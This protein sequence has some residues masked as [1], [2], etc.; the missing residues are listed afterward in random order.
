MELIVNYAETGLVLSLSLW[1]V[2]VCRPS[3]SHSQKIDCSVGKDSE[4][5]FWHGMLG[6]YLLKIGFFGQFWHGLFCYI[7]PAHRKT[8]YTKNNGNNCKY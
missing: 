2:I 5:P 7:I 3:I 1:R 8:Y 6:K 4:F